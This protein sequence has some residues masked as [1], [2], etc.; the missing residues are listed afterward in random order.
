M[1]IGQISIVFF[2]N[3]SGSGKTTLLNALSFSSKGSLKVDGKIMINGCEADATK[4]A[5]VSRYIQQEDLFFGTLT[6]K[7]HLIFHVIPTKKRTF[8]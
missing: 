5:M 6:V 2:L 4:M 8:S 3:C 7:E 1:Y